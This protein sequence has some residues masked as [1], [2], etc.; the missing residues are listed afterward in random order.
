MESFTFTTVNKT[1]RW[2]AAVLLLELTVGCRR[3]VIVRCHRCLSCCVLEQALDLLWWTSWSTWWPS[4]AV[5]EGRLLLLVTLSATVTTVTTA[6]GPMY[7]RRIFHELG[8]PSNK[9]EWRHLIQSVCTPFQWYRTCCCRWAASITA[10]MCGMLLM[11][12]R[13]CNCRSVHGRGWRAEIDVDGACSIFGRVCCQ[14]N[15]SER[16][17]I[18][19]RCLGDDNA[20]F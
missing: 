8:P 14:G 9:T 18:D 2:T 5:S 6:L 11:E 12:M 20:A 3:L 19:S 1:V 4:V 17:Q 10:T 13:R 15:E 7:I 16:V